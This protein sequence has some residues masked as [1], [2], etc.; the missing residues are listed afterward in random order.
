MT[1]KNGIK[2]KDCTSDTCPISASVYGYN[3]S[4]A[5]N[6]IF[7]ALFAISFF[8]HI[9]QGVKWKSWSF[10]ISMAIGVFGEAVGY[11]GRIMMHNDVFNGTAFKIQI[12]CLTVAP[13]FLSAGIYLTLKHT[14]IVFGASFSRIQP[15][16]YT[17]IFI[18]CDIF[19]ILIQALGAGIA[20]AGSHPQTGNSIMIFGLSLQVFT[21]SLFGLLASEYAFRVYKFR[22]QLNSASA[23][24]RRS[25]YFKGLII[26]IAV[27]YTTIL[28]RCIYRVA[29]MAGGWRNSLM[30]DQALFIVLD[31][32]MC[33]IAVLVLNI[34]H[35]GFLFQEASAVSKGESTT[36]GSMELTSQ[37]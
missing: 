9:F 2:F 16:W 37:G 35:P 11:G 30:Q 25:K 7:C 33:V 27:S 17:W 4:I 20:A 31:A 34:F 14:V 23:Q 32:V 21:L 19:S 5:A 8:L 15:R 12:I 28:I 29:E 10:L 3:P 26:A 22:H 6:G 36:A 24:L 1:T 13:A 18:G